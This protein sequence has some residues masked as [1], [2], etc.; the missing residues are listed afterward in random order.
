MFCPKCGNDM[1][2]ALFCPRCGAPAPTPNSAQAPGGAGSQPVM[3]QTQNYANMQTGMNQTGKK[4]K[5]IGLIIGIAAALLFVLVIMLSVMTVRSLKAGSDRKETAKKTEASGKK[6][7]SKEKQLREEAS[8]YYQDEFEMTEEEADEMAE[9]Y[10]EIY[11]DLQDDDDEEQEKEGKANAGFKLY[12]V[13]P[14]IASSKL[15]DEIVQVNDCV[16]HMHEDMKLREVIDRLSESVPV[17]IRGDVTEDTLI[18]AGDSISYSLDD[19]NGEELCAVTGWNGTEDYASPFDCNVR[20][21]WPP[22]DRHSKHVL[23]FWYPGNICAAIYNPLDESILASEEYLERSEEYPRMTFQNAKETL[24]GKGADSVIFVDKDPYFY[25]DNVFRVAAFSNKDMPYWNE[26]SEM[27]EIFIYIFHVNM[28]NAKVE[29]M[30]LGKVPLEKSEDLLKNTGV[31]LVDSVNILTA[32]AISNQIEERCTEFLI[33]EGKCD[34]TAVLLGYYR[35]VYTNDI[36]AICNTDRGDFVPIK[37]RKTGSKEITIS[38]TADGTLEFGKFQILTAKDDLKTFIEKQNY[39][40]AV[41]E[42]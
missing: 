4:K 28:N 18:K 3:P 9:I 1:K 21:I 11:G 13:S 6:E 17:T 8:E 36:C 27:D 30:S 35:E 41:D 33:S 22:G 25:T 10:A 40:A 12:D 34:A 2:D 38:L 31:G 19:E 29:S 32:D 26:D 37:L 23:N 7:S 5:P 14:E 39:Y 42:K 24:M 20:M 15:G 16:F